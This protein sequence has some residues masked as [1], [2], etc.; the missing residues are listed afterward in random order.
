[1][2]AR[3]TVE[4]KTLPKI[5][6]AAGISVDVV[7]KRYKAGARTI[8]E[9]SAPLEKLSA[10]NHKSAGAKGARHVFEPGEYRLPAG[11]YMSVSDIVRKTYTAFCTVTVG[12]A[13]YRLE[14]RRLNVAESLCVPAPGGG[15][16]TVTATSR[17]D[18]KSTE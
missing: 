5:A 1:M 14:I 7:R 11:G 18:A 15:L 12:A 8:A 9:L 2:M 10:Q 4:G 6:G 13:R 16:Y 17:R 3:V